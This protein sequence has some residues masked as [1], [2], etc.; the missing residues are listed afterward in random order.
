MKKVF[1]AIA[2][3]A[4]IGMVSCKKSNECKCK[5]TDPNGITTTTTHTLE[6]GHTCEQFEV[7]VA[8]YTIK[9]K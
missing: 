1:L 4:M 5:T 8:G 2:V 9:C 7:A 6:E 3:L